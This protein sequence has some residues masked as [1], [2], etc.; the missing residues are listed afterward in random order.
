MSALVLRQTVKRTGRRTLY[1]VM[2][3]HLSNERTCGCGTVQSALQVGCT[4]GSRFQANGINCIAERE[5][6][7]RNNRSHIKGEEKKGTK[8]TAH[9]AFTDTKCSNHTVLTEP[10]QEQEAPE[11]PSA[12]TGVC[13]PS[14]PGL[15][16]SRIT[17]RIFRFSSKSRVALS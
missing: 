3:E 7:Q 1:T 9:S 8:R 10:L 14:S 16:S 13:L 2:N 17:L 5:R 12:V 6:T 15:R 11:T 4:A